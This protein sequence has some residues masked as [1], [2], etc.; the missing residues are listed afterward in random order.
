MLSRRIALIIV[1]Y[2]LIS[3]PVAIGQR[4]SAPLL[5]V[6]QDGRVSAGSK[7]SLRSAVQMGLPLRIGF[8]EGVFDD[9]QKP[10]RLRVRV[11]WRI[12]PR[13]PRERLPSSMPLPK[14]GR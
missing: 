11:I 6:E 3:A 9:D 14:K 4:Y 12:D 1:I 8:L 2:A 5:V 10:A 7:E 13:V